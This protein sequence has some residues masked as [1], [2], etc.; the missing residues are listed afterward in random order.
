MGWFQSFM[1]WTRAFSFYVDCIYDPVLLAVEG[2]SADLY[3]VAFKV[4]KLFND[5]S[6][7]Y[8]QRDLLGFFFP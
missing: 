6:Q 2:N 4:I 7:I 5:R 3:S 1:T 8:K